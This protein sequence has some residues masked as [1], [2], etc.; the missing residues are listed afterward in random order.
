[1]AD[2]EFKLLDIP[3]LGCTH[4]DYPHARGEVLVRGRIFSGYY[5]QP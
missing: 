4:L 1:M 5:K 3:E 2:L